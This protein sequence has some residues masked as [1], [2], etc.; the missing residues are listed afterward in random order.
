MGLPFCPPD[1]IPTALVEL[2]AVADERIDDVLD[3][4]EDFYVLGRRR[5]RG[6]RPPVF[7]PTKWSVHAR[8]LAG[9]PR[10]N[11][12]VEGWHARMNHILGKTHPSLYSLL[13]GIFH[14]EFGCRVSRRLASL[15]RVWS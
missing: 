11:N 9:L 8:V 12:S 3:L 6:R 15:C 2:R 13:E 10:T 1:Q 5:G 4:V 14:V 7:P